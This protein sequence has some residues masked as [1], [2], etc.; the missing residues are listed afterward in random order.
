MVLA[1]ETRP[2]GSGAAGITFR[3]VDPLIAPALAVILTVPGATPRTVPGLLLSLEIP[4]N[5][6]F[7]EDQITE[8]SGDVLLSPYVP[9]AITFWERE[10][11]R[12]GA[13]AVIAIETSSGGAS[14][15]GL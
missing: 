4:A 5:E 13:G 15:A 14:I 1:L 9:I 10:G 12:L 3:E 6:G 2:R 7:E 8:G 11:E